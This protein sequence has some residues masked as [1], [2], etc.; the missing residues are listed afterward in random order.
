MEHC[1]G[2]PVFRQHPPDADGVYRTARCSACG[3]TFES[4]PAA[5]PVVPDVEP[6][7][8]IEDDAP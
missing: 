5:E 4:D 2:A 6:A 1:K 3:A 8:V 7:I